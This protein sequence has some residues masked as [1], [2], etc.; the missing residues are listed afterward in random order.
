MTFRNQ[1]NH[2]VSFT[3]DGL[4]VHQLLAQDCTECEYT[5]TTCDGSLLIPRGMQF[6]KDLFPEIVVPHNHVAPYHD[7]ITGKE[8]TFVIVGPF[9]RRDTLL[10]GIASDLELYST[11]EFITLRN[12]GMFK[13][14]SSA[15][16]SLP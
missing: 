10:H 14:A 1:Q 13:S 7:P 9:A 3:A 12:A 4:L 16:Q 6:P 11:E 5:M 15:S 2:P 8:A